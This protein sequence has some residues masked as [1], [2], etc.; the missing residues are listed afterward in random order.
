MPWLL[1]ALALPLAA[2]SQGGATGTAPSDGFPAPDKEFVWNVAANVLE[3]EG[4]APDRESSSKQ[5]WTIVSHWKLSLQPFSGQGYR[6]RATVTIHDVPGRPGHYYTETQ[7]V[8]QLNMNMTQP[9][10]PVV[11]TWAQEQR[12]PDLEDLINGRIELTFLP[13]GVSPQFEQRYGTTGAGGG[14]ID[15]GTIQREPPPATPVYVPPCPLGSGR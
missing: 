6:D 8:R 1:V 11:A 13:G 12:S 14:R 10:N 2:C 9:G 4:L 15:A 7:V 5:T 3:R